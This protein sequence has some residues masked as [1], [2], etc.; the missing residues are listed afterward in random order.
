MIASVKQRIRTSLFVRFFPILALFSASVNRI[1]YGKGAR[2]RIGGTA[3]PEGLSSR[4]QN[5]QEHLSDTRPDAQPGAIRTN[6]GSRVYKT[7]G[8]AARGSET[9]KKQRKACCE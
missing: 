7:P 4:P 8:H 6:K 1:R 9:E 2:K 5:A 3:G